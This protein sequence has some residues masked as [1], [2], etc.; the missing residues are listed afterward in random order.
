MTTAAEN[1]RT[2]PK[3]S[4]KEVL[5]IAIL[6]VSQPESRHWLT[7]NMQSRAEMGG[8]GGGDGVWSAVRSGI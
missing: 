2:W 1:D 3:V 8:A 4:V 6:N 5:N 7:V